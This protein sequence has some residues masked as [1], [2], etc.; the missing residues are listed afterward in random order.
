[1]PFEQL[2]RVWRPRKRREEAIARGAEHEGW[3]RG[4]ENTLAVLLDDVLEDANPCH[5]RVA[6]W[7]EERYRYF[8]GDRQTKQEADSHA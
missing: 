5:E 7:A 4:V 6:E 2:M 8:C 1:M 3:L